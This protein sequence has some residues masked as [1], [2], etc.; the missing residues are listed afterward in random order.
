MGLLESKLFRMPDLGDGEGSSNRLNSNLGL[1]LPLLLVG[2]GGA[3]VDVGVFAPVD[4]G[5]P[6]LAVRPI[7]WLWLLCLLFPYCNR[8]GEKLELPTLILA[9]VA[10]VPD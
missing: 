4:F 2:G 9:V 6:L 8:L 7:M 3:T 1:S 5:E 10:V